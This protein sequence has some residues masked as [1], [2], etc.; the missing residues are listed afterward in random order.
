MSS[1]S[2]SEGKVDAKKEG[3]EEM[4]AFLAVEGNSSKKC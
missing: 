4:S 1:S 3:L 2:S